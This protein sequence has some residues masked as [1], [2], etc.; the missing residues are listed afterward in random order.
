MPK[1]QEVVEAVVRAC[2][3]L[4]SF[5]QHE[6]LSLGQIVERTGLSKTTCFRLL[7]SLTKGQMIERVAKGA[8]RRTIEQSITPTYTIGFAAQTSGSEFSR[9]DSHSTRR[10]V[11]REHMRVIAVNNRYSPKVALRNADLWNKKR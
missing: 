5:H 4:Q 8:Y 7:Q 1:E 9:D 11:E 3:V 10:V 2:R 6:V